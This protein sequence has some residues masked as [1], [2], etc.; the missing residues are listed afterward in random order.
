MANG[1]K[2]TKEVVLGVMALVKVVAKEL[3]DGFQVMDLVAAF[4]A[5]QADPVKKAALEAALKDI[6]DVPEE[7]KDASLAEW[8][9]VAVV[10]ISE[11]PSLLAAF[12]KE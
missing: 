8:I 4:S 6:G 11:L 7:I 5:I 9:E 2:E 10:L 1:I 12:K 3:K